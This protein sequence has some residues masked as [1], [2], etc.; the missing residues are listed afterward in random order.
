VAARPRLRRPGP[1]RTRRSLPAG[2]HRAQNGTG[3][4]THED[5]SVYKGQFKDGQFAGKGARAPRP[6]PRAPRPAP[7]RPA[8]ARAQTSGPRGMALTARCAFTEILCN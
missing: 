4:M 3:E 8:R 5:G 1:F 2:T 6:A 7:R